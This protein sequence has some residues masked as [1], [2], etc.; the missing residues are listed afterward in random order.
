MSDFIGTDVFVALQKSLH[1]R[2]SEFACNSIISNGGRIMNVLDP[3]VFGWDKLRQTA[4][5]DLLVGITMV[6]RDTT[7]AKLSKL[8]GNDAE[9]PYWQV[10]TGASGTVL[11]RCEALLTAQPLPD[12]WTLQSFT[13]PSEGIIAQS[14]NLNIETDVAPYPGYYLQ[15]E[16]MPSM[17][18]CIFD[19]TGKMIVCAS[20]NMRYHADSPFAKWMFAGGV[21]VHPSQRRRGL[22]SYVSAALLRDSHASFGW[23]TVLE[24]AKADNLP[25]VGMITKCGLTAVLNKVTI[26][27]NLTGGYVTR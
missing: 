1:A 23:T 9:F 2:Q 6:D 17:L 3:E 16:V 25:S 11:P 7:L 20:G 5:E 21:S 26:V 10:F 14:Q 22:G 27:V 13:H 15:G 24:Q 4:E 12:G 18:T 8:F 19:E